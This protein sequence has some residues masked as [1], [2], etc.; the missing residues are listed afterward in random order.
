MIKAGIAGAGGYAGQELIRILKNHPDVKI[1]CMTARSDAGKRYDTV[2]GNYKEIEER[3]L[4]DISLEDMAEKCDV[5]F[6]ALPAGAA[7]EGVTEGVLNKTKIIDLG[8][9]FRL[10]NADDYEN[11]TS[12]S[13]TTGKY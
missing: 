9:D 4:S 5:V 7:A 12:L 3:E 10:K 13:I 11:G 1:E 8:G 2:Y 6:I